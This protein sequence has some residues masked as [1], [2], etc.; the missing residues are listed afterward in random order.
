LRADIEGLAELGYQEVVLTGTH[1]GGYGEDRG[2]SLLELL[3]LLAKDCPVPRIRLSSIDP[4]DLS[5]ELLD[6]VLESDVFCEHLH[7]CIQAFSDKVLKRMNRR[8]R[9]ED[10]RNI[11]C[12]ISQ[13]VPGICIGTDVIT[14]FPGESRQEVDQG[15]EEFLRLPISYLHVFPYSERSGT[16]A[17]RL[18]GSIDVAERRRRSSRWRSIAQREKENYYASRQGSMLEVVVERQESGIVYGT[19][20]EYI[21]AKFAAPARPLEPGSLVYVEGLAVDT[22]DKKLLCQLSNQENSVLGLEQGSPRSRVVQT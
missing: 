5:T 12:Y 20:R 10:V 9:M 1:I 22:E 2:E 3:Q 17:T 15:V 8:Y 14:G 13:K 16:A 4:N 19:S 7:I 18:D 11:L 6:F 21:A